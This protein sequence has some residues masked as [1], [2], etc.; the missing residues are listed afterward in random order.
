MGAKLA[1]LALTRWAPHVPDRAFRVLMRMA[2]TALDE[3]QN[4]TQAGLYFGGRDLLLSCLRAE[5]GGKRDTQLR[6]LRK[7][8]NE[9]VEMGAVRRTNTAYAG[10]NQVYELTLFAAIR[11]D[12]EPVDNSVSVADKGDPQAPPLEDP[13]APP[14]GVPG[15]PEWGTPTHPPRNQEEPIEELREEISLDLRGHVTA[16]RAK[17]KPQNAEPDP[18]NVPPDKCPEPGCAKGFVLRGDRITHCP[19]CRSNVIS[20][21][22]RPA[23]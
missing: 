23:A 18:P 20:M 19:Q 13:Q 17:S 3:A 22:E 11:F 21:P 6:Q 16:S 4:G 5:R 12:A 1:T 9:L 2:L 8:I 10:V 15:G 14:V 7:A